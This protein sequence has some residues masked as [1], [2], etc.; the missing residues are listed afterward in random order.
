MDIKSIFSNASN[1]SNIGFQAEKEL[2]NCIVTTNAGLF[3]F[4][5][6]LHKKVNDMETFKARVQEF[7]KTKEKYDSIPSSEYSYKFKYTV[8][9]EFGFNIAHYIAMN[10]KIEYLKEFILSIG[11][12]MNTDTFI[13]LFTTEDIFGQ[14][15]K[16]IMIKNNNSEMLDYYVNYAFR[17][18]LNSI[19]AD[20]RDTTKKRKI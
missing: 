6:N 4:G 13:S 19:A 9:D 7:L 8:T 12:Q 16:Q 20:V 5:F 10:N 18:S 17:R 3:G 1:D 14:T 2:L 15:A 11:S